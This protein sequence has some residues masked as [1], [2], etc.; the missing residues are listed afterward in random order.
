MNIQYQS[1]FNDYKSRNSPQKRWKSVITGSLGILIGAIIVYVMLLIIDADWGRWLFFFVER[2]LTYVI[3]SYLIL[4]LLLG[5][6]AFK[7]ASQD[8]INIQQYY[9]RLKEYQ[10]KADP[11]LKDVK[12]LANVM[13]EKL[14]YNNS[15]RDEN[16]E[17]YY[18]QD[19]E[20]INFFPVPPIS[21][22]NSRTNK[23]IRKKSEVQ[24]YEIVGEKFYENKISGGGSEGPNYAGAFI[25]G[26]IMGTAGA[27]V[28]GQQKI[29]PITSELILHDTRKTR[30]VFTYIDGVNELLCDFS[31]FEILK[32]NL[33]EK[34]RDIV[35]EVTKHKIVYGEKKE[36][37]SD[38]KNKFVVLEQLYKD[39]YLNK[40]EYDAKKK[41]L[42][43][44]VL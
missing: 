7:K 34:S 20:S 18:W 16:F 11:I 12:P 3:A 36:V 19:K 25:G 31:F 9:E 2:N 33:P 40:E 24:F 10:V 37:V 1:L 27:I 17:Y 13:V 14:V 28:G 29:D 8:K 15:W 22:F 5:A 6:N 42:I 44:E 23:I 30:V 32:R 39:G 26:Q 38:L 43:D 41:K 4:I 35:D 21:L